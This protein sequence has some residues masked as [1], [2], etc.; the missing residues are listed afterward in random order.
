MQLFVYDCLD[1]P[2]HIGDYFTTPQRYF[3]SMWVQVGRVLGFKEI[4]V[5]D[6]SELRP[7]VRTVQKCWKDGWQ[8]SLRNAVL[9]RADRATIV[10]T[11]SIPPELVELLPAHPRASPRI[12]L[13]RSPERLAG[14]RAHD[15]EAVLNGFVEVALT[16]HITGFF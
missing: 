11:S 8:P 16:N 12:P 6:G 15:G 5:R 4:N 9:E 7:I 14:V 10:S 13:V 1:R 2:F 3:S